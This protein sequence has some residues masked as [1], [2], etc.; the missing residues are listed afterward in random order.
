MPPP[1]PGYPPPPPPP[2]ASGDTYQVGGKSAQRKFYNPTPADARLPWNDHDPWGGPS[3]MLSAP[4]SV[5][6]F[7]KGKVKGAGSDLTVRFGGRVINLV[8]GVYL[9]NNAAIFGVGLLHL[10]GTPLYDAGLP[11]V[12]VGVL[13]PAFEV[14]TIR[15][16][17][18]EVY[19][20][21][22]GVTGMRITVEDF[23]KIDLRVP[24]VGVWMGTQVEDK[25]TMTKPDPEVA[26]SWGAMLDMGITFAL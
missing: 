19:N 21:Q 12:Q 13:F 17:D 2:A 4:L 8:G 20:V 22:I 10:A 1:T 6:S 16:K 11:D 3:W 14:R 26:V 18:I 25:V 15:G 5:H 7:V 23:L 24:T 9:P